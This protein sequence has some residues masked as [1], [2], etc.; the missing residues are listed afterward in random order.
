MNF[1][2][3]KILQYNEPLW[4]VQLYIL[5]EISGSNWTIEVQ[6]T[7][8]YPKFLGIG[9]EFRMSKIFGWVIGY[10]AIMYFLLKIFFSQHIF[11]KIFFKIF[12]SFFY[13]K[14]GN[15]VGVSVNTEFRIT[16]SRISSSVL[17]VFQM[18][19]QYSD[20]LR[21]ILSVALYQTEN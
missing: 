7:S 12:F 2:K 5:I 19:W 1:F 9:I 8:S 3:L 13:S 20:I 4:F 17:Y 21:K 15:K 6:Y 11:F 16:A 14:I 10:D 18:N